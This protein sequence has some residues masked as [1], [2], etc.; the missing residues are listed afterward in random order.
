MGALS[1]AGVRHAFARVSPT[2]MQAL[3]R[4]KPAPGARSAETALGRPHKGPPF[5]IP[6]RPGPPTHMPTQ[7]RRR[8]CCIG[9]R[10]CCQ[11]FGTRVI[12]AWCMWTDV[13]ADI[14]AVNLHLYR[15][16]YRQTCKHVSRHESRH[17]SRSAYMCIG[18][19]QDMRTARLRLKRKPPTGTRLI[20]LVN[21]R[22]V[23]TCIYR[24]DK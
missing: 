17:V 8:P 10:M 9:G 4:I 7:M 1:Q 5:R 23:Q 20:L 11:C 19:R 16:S 21:A 15:H 14:C 13:C 3:E 12:E 22:R 2:R 24:C 18:M 6:A